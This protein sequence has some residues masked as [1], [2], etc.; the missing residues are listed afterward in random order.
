MRLLTT[1]T[2]CTWILVFFSTPNVTQSRVFLGLV[3]RRWLGRHGRNGNFE[4]RISP[5]GCGLF[6]FRLFRP[7]L[8]TRGHWHG[9]STVHCYRISAGLRVYCIAYS[10]TQADGPL[11]Y[12]RKGPHR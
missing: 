8:S 3:F 6:F 9:C 1:T 12:S 5:R 7:H 2:K 11:A 10:W 4:N